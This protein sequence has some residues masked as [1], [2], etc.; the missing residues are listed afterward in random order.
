MAMRSGSGRTSSRL[1]KEKRSRTAGREGK[2][3]SSHRVVEG[4]PGARVVKGLYCGQRRTG[5]HGNRPGYAGGRQKTSPLPAEAGGRVRD[6][7]GKVKD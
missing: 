6:L 3:Y 4:E 7:A 1:A 2:A 5:D